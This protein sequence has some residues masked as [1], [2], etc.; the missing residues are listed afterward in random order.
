MLL[1]FSGGPLNIHAAVTSDNVAAIVHC[2]FP[3]QATGTAL[4]NMITMATALSNPSARL[5][6]TWYTSLEQVCIFIIL[7]LKGHRHDW[8]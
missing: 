3:A 8:G 5:P 4:F 2:F 7:D 1:L 6:F